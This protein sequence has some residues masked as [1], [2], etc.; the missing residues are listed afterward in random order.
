MVAHSEDAG[1]PFRGLPKPSM[2]QTGS[3]LCFVSEVRCARRAPHPVNSPSYVVRK[4]EVLS[5]V[6]V[7]GVLD[8][9]NARGS[10]PSAVKWII[11]GDS[12]WT[13]LRRARWPECARLVGEQ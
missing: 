8:V 6:N 4:I 11:V 7:H 3:A 5:H 2:Y 1:L 10:Q 9:D 12:E 13:E